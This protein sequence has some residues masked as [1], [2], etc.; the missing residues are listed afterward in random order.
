MSL[1]KT[2]IGL[3][4]LLIVSHCNVTSARYLQSD[5]VGLRG[6]INTYEYVRGNPVNAVDPLGLTTIYY[7]PGE[8]TM[9]VYPEQPGRPSYYIPATSGRPNCGCDASSPNN[10][11]T[12]SGDYTMNS[13]DLSNPPWYRDIARNSPGFGADWGDWRTPMKPNAG[14]NTYGRS[15]FYMH[16]GSLPGS[17]G[18]IDVGGGVFGNTVSDQLLNDI[19]NDPDGIIPVFV[20]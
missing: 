17:A 11:P 18:C 20:K 10:G 19:M 14:T 7:H 12:P 13:K 16:G 5:P 8:Q 6:G 2:L 15:G 3:L 1:N 4:A 9:S